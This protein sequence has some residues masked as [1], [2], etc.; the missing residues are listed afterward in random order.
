[1]FAYG[2]IVFGSRNDSA[3]KHLS[4]RS[5][6]GQPHLRGFWSQSRQCWWVLQCT[7]ACCT[8][9]SLSKGIHTDGHSKIQCAWQGT[10]AQGSLGAMWLSAAGV[11]DVAF[12]KF[13]ELEDKVRE[14]FQCFSDSNRTF[15]CSGCAVEL[16]E[17]H[18][19]T[20]PLLVLVHIT[21][22]YPFILQEGFKISYQ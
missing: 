17:D 12:L 19:F 3:E 5:L 18:R 6:S 20:A 21:V 1:M 8:G 15:Y 2:A 10:G 4:G 9:V 7:L 11:Q 16:T 22:K 13:L 14:E